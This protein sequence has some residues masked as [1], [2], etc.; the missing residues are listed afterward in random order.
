MTCLCRLCAEFVTRSA[1]HRRLTLG[2][3]ATAASASGSV[4]RPASRALPA[5]APSQ[6]RSRTSRRSSIDAIPP[7]AITGSP[8]GSDLLEELEIRAGKRAVAGRARHE[9]PR[10]AG[11]GAACGELDG[12]C[13]GGPRPAVDGDAAVADVDRDD[14]RVAEALRRRL[15]ERGLER[16]RADHHAVGARSIAPRSL[17]ASGSRRRPGPGAP[18]R[19]RGARGAR[20]T[21]RRRTRRRG[22]RGA[23][24]S[25]PLTRTA[26]RAR[27]DRRLR[28]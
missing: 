20:A 22:R 4:N 19:P 24:A 10:D 9:Q 7:A 21:G 6:P 15:E 27:R 1:S 25:R 16:R 5:I 26:A 11:L 2:Y 18:S 13:P 17:R 28:A 12:R 3:A 23:D 14:E 8:T